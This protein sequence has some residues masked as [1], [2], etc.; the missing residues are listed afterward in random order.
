MILIVD[1]LRNSVCIE[2]SNRFHHR[3][4]KHVFVFFAVIV[5]VSTSGLVHAVEMHRAT[6]GRAV[7]K[8]KT[9]AAA[10]ANTI[11][12]WITLSVGLHCK[13]SYYNNSYSY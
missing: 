12:V 9:S 2:D 3:L 1:V 6:S 8:L 13:N 7:E 10:A 4:K 5:G 11:E